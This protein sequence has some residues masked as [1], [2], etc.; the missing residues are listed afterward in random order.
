MIRPVLALTLGL[1]L[2]FSAS[3]AAAEKLVKKG[4]AGTSVVSL[5]TRSGTIVS[6]SN[7]IVVSVTDPKG[8]PKPAKVES[9]TI[10]MPPMPGMDAMYGKAVL[11][12]AR[13]PGVYQGTLEVE[14]KGPWKA[15]VAFRD[16]KGK[17][18]AVM[19][20]VAR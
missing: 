10:Y 20:I 14:M 19:N 3:A 4:K 17:H 5:L 11:K 9:L 2:A 15:T 8:N 6:G 16:E 13:M 1:I 12:P 7:A 18:D